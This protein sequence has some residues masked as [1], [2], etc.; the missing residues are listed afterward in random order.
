M[1]KT[2]PLKEYIKNPKKTEHT[3]KE[4]E[5]SR[6]IASFPKDKIQ[7]CEPAKAEGTTHATGGL[8]SLAS[9]QMTAS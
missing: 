5:L 9:I 8:M 3:S 2:F 6:M 7:K 1:T 4:D